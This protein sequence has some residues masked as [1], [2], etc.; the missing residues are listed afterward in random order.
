[1]VVFI[2]APVQYATAMY[3]FFDTE[4]TGLPRS[5][6]A[7]VEDLDNWPRLVQIAWL[8][9]SAAGE[10]TERGNFIIRPEGFSIPEESSRIHGIT[11]ER[12]MM[13]GVP[14][15]TALRAFQDALRGADTVV[16]HNVSFDE[17]IV[18]AEFLR[19]NMANDVAAKMK[20]CTMQGGKEYCAL[21]GQ[22]GLKWPRLSE[23]HQKLF[24]VDFTEA[25]DAASD[26]KATARCFWEM[27]RLG[28][29]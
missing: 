15:A 19:A 9:Y 8:S 29:L 18:G 27:K 14:L 3:V 4:T 13:E 1:M 17:K 23:L 11:T 22:Y 2:F 16:A 10:E 5:W 7:P 21:P 20:I 6:K 24:G 12:A 28:V 25:H 26:I